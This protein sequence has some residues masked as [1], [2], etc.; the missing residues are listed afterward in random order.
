MIEPQ[1]ILLLLIAISGL[2]FGSFL[3]VV[4][5]RIPIMLQRSWQKEHLYFAQVIETEQATETTVTLASVDNQTS[6]KDSDTDDNQHFNIAW[7]GSHCPKCQHKIAP[8]DNIPLISYL[9]LKG[10]CRHCHD[11]IPIRYP[12]VEL[13]GGVLAVVSALTFGVSLTALIYFAVSLILLALLVIDLQTQLLP[14]ILTL[15][16]LWAGLIFHSLQSE[17]NLNLY[18]WGVVAGYFSLWSI[19]W[20]FK[21]ATGKEGM[22]YG[23]FK[24]LA[25]LGAW[26]GWIMLPP[27]MLISALSGLTLALGLRLSGKLQAGQA[28]PFGPALAI[29]GW[30]ALYFPDDI[31]R[32]MNTLFL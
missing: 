7:P 20:L 1:G 16:L 13:S 8:Y 32:V 28:M 5:Y 30:L 11:A 10:R 12:L 6:E 26:A 9:L 17:Q 14:D 19:Y 24:L 29:A 4:I 23:D 2:L 27:I 18:L 3:N 15:P 22:G 25:A 31:Q 21:L